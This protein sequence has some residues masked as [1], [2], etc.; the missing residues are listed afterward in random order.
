LAAELVRLALVIAGGLFVSDDP[1]ADALV[2]LDQAR[3]IIADDK[4]HPERPDFV[5]HEIA[6]G[7]AQANA[8]AAAWKTLDGIWTTHIRVAAL[9]RLSIVYFRRGEKER[10]ETTLRQ[11]EALAAADT[12]PLFP[13]R[14]REIAIAKL[15][16]DEPDEAIKIFRA[17]KLVGH[18]I[19]RLVAAHAACNGPRDA[20]SFTERILG[21][22]LTADELWML[23]EIAEII[24]QYGAAD[25]LPAIS[26]KASELLPQ[27]NPLVADI[28]MI[29]VARCYRLSGNNTEAL[30]RLKQAQALA[31]EIK[32]KGARIDMACLIAEMYATLG[33]KE[34]A[35]AESTV[36]DKRLRRQ[37][38][39]RVAVGLAEGG[40][41]DDALDMASHLA[42]DHHTTLALWEVAEVAARKGWPKMAAKTIVAVYTPPE[43][44]PVGLATDPPVVRI[45]LPIM[46]IIDS[47]GIFVAAKIRG[48]R[49]VCEALS[50]AGLP[51]EA[52]SL[53]NALK[54]HSLSSDETALGLVSVAE[55]MIAA[56]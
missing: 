7:Y 4:H 9:A 23:P 1:H 25:D 40:R 20:L 37:V 45:S 43:L 2:C 22:G 51:G 46:D 3:Q 13:M 5:L 48:L 54:R 38:L 36:V 10:A 12:P 14:Y 35:I 29:C 26:R 18:A 42:H 44:P 49:A 17:H 30:R 6:L 11:A 15:G 47:E 34:S 16:M 50:T 52:L 24:S 32:S 33:D 39:E 28:N 41:V 21:R 27:S 31:S 19:I 53:L 56:E 55:G 8:D